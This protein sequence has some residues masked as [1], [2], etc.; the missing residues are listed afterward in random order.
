MRIDRYIVNTIAIL[1]LLGAFHAP[2]DWYFRA[3]SALSTLGLVVLIVF[4]LLQNEESR[5][6][7]KSL[8]IFYVINLIIV[9][10]ITGPYFIQFLEWIDSKNSD[11]LIMFF[12]LVLFTP[13]SWA[14][15]Y[16]VGIINSNSKE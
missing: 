1:Y 6:E 3:L 8:I 12:I 2:F 14:V 7:N 16:F 13:W 4:H 10:P 5:L 15:I 11:L 9:N